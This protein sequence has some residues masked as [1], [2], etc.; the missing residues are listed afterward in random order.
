MNSI[1]IPHGLN[2]LDPLKGCMETLI[3]LISYHHGNTRKIID[4]VATVLDAEVKE[5]TNISPEALKNYDLVGF[6]S[7]IYYDKMDKRITRFVE[8]LPPGNGSC[9]ILTTSGG[10][11]E[12]AH[13]EMRKLIA[14][15]GYKVRSEWNCRALDTFG[16]LTL[17]GGI[18]KGKPDPN[19]IRSARLFAEKLKTI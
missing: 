3:L 12:K 18:N 17:I 7:G 11:H 1:P 10:T 13:N 4:E 5:P 2:E 8:N 14:S 15:K 19:D 16:P 9:F 6:A